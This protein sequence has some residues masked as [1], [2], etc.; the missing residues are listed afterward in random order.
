MKKDKDK[1]EM[2][3]YE[4]PQDE[5]AIALYGEEWRRDYLYIPH[6]HNLLEIG[7][8]LEGHGTYL[9]ED[10]MRYYTPGAL[11]IIPSN[12]IHST[13]SDEIGA[14]AYWEYIFLDVD[15]LLAILY[16]E[17]KILRQKM[18]RLINE[19][20]Y[21]MRKEEL[22]ELYMSIQ[23]IFQEMKGK[24]KFYKAS[25]FGICYAILMQ[26]ARMNENS[27]KEKKYKQSY[28]QIKIGLAF[29]H[30][31]Y[32]ESLKISDIAEICFMSE[33]HFRRSFEENLGMTPVEY[34]ND[35]RITKACELIQQKKGTMKEIAVKVGFSTIS[36]FNR[37]F[38]AFLGVS[39]K[40]WK[41]DPNNYKRNL[42]DFKILVRKGW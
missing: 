33:S 6:V 9:L 11:T 30:D 22:P 18:S 13:Q 19:K 15:K 5:Y 10:E 41:K 42:E 27:K 8:C 2:R 28:E 24:K 1:I 4:M 23:L 32:N 37:N 26:I 29:I 12:H 21:L 17:D 14:M 3:Y 25:V 39:P 36:T 7:I 20:S 40:E 34:I 16:P 38:K 31:H 35:Y